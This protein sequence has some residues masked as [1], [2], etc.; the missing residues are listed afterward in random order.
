MDVRGE[1]GQRVVDR[2]DP[3]VGI[4]GNDGVGGVV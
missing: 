2:I 1:S 3:T 4:A